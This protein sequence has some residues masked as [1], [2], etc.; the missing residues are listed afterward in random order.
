MNLIGHA[1]W[2]ENVFNTARSWCSENAVANIDD[3]AAEK[4]IRSIP[5]INIAIRIIEISPLVFPSNADML[6]CRCAIYVGSAHVVVAMALF[7]DGE[8]G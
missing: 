6:R 5:I 4:R 8:I 3:I 7:D 1:F 2:V